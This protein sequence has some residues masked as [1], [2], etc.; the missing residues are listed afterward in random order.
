M[1][2]KRGN[3]FIYKGQLLKYNS[4]VKNYN[5]WILKLYNVQKREL[6]VLPVEYRC[7]LVPATKLDLLLR[8]LDE[9]IR[10]SGSKTAS[11]GKRRKTQRSV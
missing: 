4:E 1:N 7:F 3:Y 6:V 11:T 2:F 9:N 10:I 8:G 5:S